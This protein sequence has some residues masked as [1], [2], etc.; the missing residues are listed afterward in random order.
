M[1]QRFLRIRDELIQVSDEDRSDVAINHI[2]AFK[3]KVTRYCKQLEQIGITT[4]YLQT[5]K[6]PP[7]HCQNSLD[8]L[9]AEIQEGL[10]HSESPFY[11]CLLKK[12]YIS[13]D[14]IVMYNR[15]FERG[16]F[17]IQEGRTAI[18]T[19]EKKMACERLLIP[20]EETDEEKEEAGVFT[21][22]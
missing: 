8:L 18:M 7:S 20:V 3:N 5:R 4:K 14:A 19:R 13:T 17:K 11:H 21:A 6:L 22:D 12:R 2:E 15:A 16:V 9:I 1:L 10:N